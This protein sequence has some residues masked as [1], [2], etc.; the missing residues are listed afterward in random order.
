ME[1]GVSNDARATVVRG[2]EG[3]VGAKL[4]ESL[5]KETDTRHVSRGGERDLR[6]AIS[7]STRSV[8]PAAVRRRAVELTPGEE[9]RSCR[10]RPTELSQG[11]VGPQSRVRLGHIRPCVARIVRTT[12]RS[13]GRSQQIGRA[14]N[15]VEART[16]EAGQVGIESQERHGKQNIQ[17]EM[18]FS[19]RRGD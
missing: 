16:R 11:Q 9:I 17:G 14:G 1:E 18:N 15:M 6:E 19:A 13:K 12:P 4:S 7:S 3:S 8:D 10:F 2:S 5:E